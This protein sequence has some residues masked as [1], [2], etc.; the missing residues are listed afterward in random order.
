MCQASSKVGHNVAKAAAGIH[1]GSPAT[2]LTC[3]LTALGIRQAGC[4]VTLTQR[5][6][7]HIPPQ[8][9]QLQLGAGQLG[10]LLRHARPE[11]LYLL[12]SRLQ[13]LLNL[14]VSFFNVT[15]RLVCSAHIA[16]ASQAKEDCVKWYLLMHTLLQWEHQ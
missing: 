5:H 14:F 6:V 3:L 7:L 16:E 11:G 1:V 4:S 10:I 15:W 9:L 8:V 2:K 13:G 12:V